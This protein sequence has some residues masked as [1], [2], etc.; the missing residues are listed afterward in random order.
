MK[1]Y[2]GGLLGVA[3]LVGCG[4]SGTDVNQYDPAAAT[5]DES[6]A[7]LVSAKYAD[8]VG[9]PVLDS[10]VA[11]AVDGDVAAASCWVTLHY[12]D[13]PD[14]Y[15]GPTCSG[16]DGCNQRRVRGTCRLLKSRVCGD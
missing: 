11:A 1:A 4:T 8:T 15:G 9:M 14:W 10:E 13:A 6:I 2:I 7:R 16:T 12:C 3:V 5:N